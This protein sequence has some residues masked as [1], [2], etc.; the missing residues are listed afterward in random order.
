MPKLERLRRPRR[1]PA[2]GWPGPLASGIPAGPSGWPAARTSSPVA[3]TAT[4]G[5][6]RT[7][8]PA[9]RR[10]QPP[11]PRPPASRGRPPCRDHV[12]GA[13]VASR[14]A[15]IALPPTPT[16]S[17]T[18]H[19]AGRGPVASR[20]RGPGV[21]AASSGVVSSTGTTA[22]APG[23]SGAPVAMRTAVPSR[24]RT[25]GDAPGRAP[26]R[27]PSAARGRPSRGACH[28]G[29]ADR[30]AVHRRVV[31]RRQRRCRGHRRGQHP[32]ERSLGRERQVF[33]PG[34]RRQRG[35]SPARPRSGVSSLT[36]CGPAAEHHRQPR[37]DGV[38]RRLARHHAH[39]S[40][41]LDHREPVEARAAASVSMTPPDRRPWR[42]QRR[43]RRRRHHLGG[44]RGGQPPPP[45]APQRA[46][47]PRP[48]R[49]APRRPPGTRDGCP[50]L[51]Q[52]GR[53]R[54]HREA[55]ARRAGRRATSAAATVT[56]RTACSSAARSLQRRGTRRRAATRAPRA[57]GRAPGRPPG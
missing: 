2:S 8:A 18:R 30:V 22:S 50:A 21:P 35:P 9:R 54:V 14:P 36:A 53:E 6:R 46:R 47:R 24:T 23:G 40:T 15:R 31:P 49:P 39:E 55:G 41:L 17:W 1:G 10:R 16:A 33:A 19:A 48:R 45:E 3:S 37:A 25:S 4:H 56:P 27:P 44:A 42:N 20:P 34:A 52:L 7:R 11:A 26:R 5:R 13:D 51:A 28:V 43:L 38:R 29:G 57:S 12:A 32:A